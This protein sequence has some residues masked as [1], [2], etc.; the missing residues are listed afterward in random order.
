M[1]DVKRIP[2]RRKGKK[3]RTMYDNGS[4]WG[5]YLKEHIRGLVSNLQHCERGSLSVYASRALSSDKSRWFDMNT[6]CIP[7]PHTHTQISQYVKRLLP[8]AWS[9][10]IIPYEK[11]IENRLHVAITDLQLNSH[12]SRINSGSQHLARYVKSSIQHIKER[13]LQS[14]SS[15][16]KKTFCFMLFRAK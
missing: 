14:F 12:L 10:I 4:K 16:P 2:M 8:S 9:F 6:G 1:T 11:C 5:I 15:L 13:V 3:K 7:P